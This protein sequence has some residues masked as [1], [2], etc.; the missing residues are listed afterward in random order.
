VIDS[1]VHHWTDPDE[2]RHVDP[3]PPAQRKT[4]DRIADAIDPLTE[5]TK[6]ES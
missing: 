1:S 4:L 6:G 2:W 5:A 3:E